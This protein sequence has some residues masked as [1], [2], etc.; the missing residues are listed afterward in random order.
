VLDRGAI[1]ERGAHAEL[2]AADG[3]YARMWRL[4][5]D[6]MRDRSA[7]AVALSTV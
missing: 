1:A 7:E 4:Q 5:Q 2:L 3:V 6:Q